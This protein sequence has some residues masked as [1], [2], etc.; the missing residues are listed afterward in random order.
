M[1]FMKRCWR[2]EKKLWR[3]FWLYDL[4]GQIAIYFLFIIVIFLVI[5]VFTFLGL[6]TDKP[7]HPLLL[8]LG[9]VKER[10]RFGRKAKE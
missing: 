9:I 5:A 4:L 8:L 6:P 3:V 1:G 7:I 2:G 10:N